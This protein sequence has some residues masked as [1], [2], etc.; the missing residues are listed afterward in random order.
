M[1]IYYIIDSLYVNKDLFVYRKSYINLI[2]SK[3]EYQLIYPPILDEQEPYVIQNNCY[4][5]PKDTPL[6]YDNLVK[7]LCSILIS[8]TF[9]LNIFALIFIYKYR[10]CR[11]I[12]FSSFVFLRFYFFATFV[13]ISST[14]FFSIEPKNYIIC[15]CRSWFFSIG[16]CLI[17]SVLLLKAW[18]IQALF[19]NKALKKVLY[20]YIDCYN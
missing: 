11:I 13:P 16:C 19:H 3:T 1:Y 8:I 10:K 20:I 15:L 7:I 6:E 12:Q 14:I 2:K 18:R 9:L 17:L 4:F 5:G